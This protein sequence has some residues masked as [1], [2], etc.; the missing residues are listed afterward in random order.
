MVWGAVIGAGL[1]LASSIFGSSS[2]NAAAQ[3][4]YREALR[5]AQRQHERDVKEW[6]ISYQQSLADWEWERAQIEQLRFNERQAQADHEWYSSRLI[7]SALENL[8]INEGAISDRFITEENLRRVQVQME[9]TYSQNRL[10]DESN[11]QLRQYLSGINQRALNSTMQV[12]QATRENQELMTSM[13]LEEQRD[14]LG[15]QINSIQSLVRD[16]ESKGRQVIRQN[17]GASAKRQAADAARALGQRYGELEMATSSRQARSGLAN[18]AMSSDLAKS[19]A[20]NALQ[21]QDSV[22]AMRH[23]NLR[24]MRDF[25]MAERTFNRLTIPSFRLAARQGERELQSLVL[26]TQQAVDRASMPYRPQTFLDPLA[27][28]AGLRPELVSPTR[29]STQS[30]LGMLGGALMGGVQGA[31][32]FSYRTSSGELAFY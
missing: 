7:Q 13:V 1:G 23:T 24:Y 30:T 31:M 26:E 17:G 11:E 5:A 19:I 28:I 16:A 22:E 21:V 32:Q 10:A 25:N 27:P 12:S 9:Y 6:Q 18:R 3:Q 8:A 29:P 2:A 4:Q 15:W 14:H 20:M